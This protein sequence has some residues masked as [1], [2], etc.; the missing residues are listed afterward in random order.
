MESKNYGTVICN[1]CGTRVDIDDAESSYNA[2]LDDV[3]FYCSKCI[4]DPAYLP[5]VS[6][7]GDEAVEHKMHPT[8]FGVCPHGVN[9]G[10]QACSAC[11]PEK[12]GVG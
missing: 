10:N 2:E 3:V 9:L 11:E 5:A 7:D 8:A 4:H 12:F 1:E 6:D